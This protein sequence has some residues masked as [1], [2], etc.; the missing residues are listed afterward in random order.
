MLLYLSY[1]PTEASVC[2]LAKKRVTSDTGLDDLGHPFGLNSVYV[3]DKRRR[4]VP[5]GCIGELC[6]SGPQVALGYLKDPEQT[7]KVFFDNPFHSGSIM[8]ATGDLVRLS[9]ID[10]SI[11]YLGRRDTQVKIRG[12]RVELGEIEEVL[13]AASNAVANAAVVKVDIGHEALVAFLQCRSDVPRPDIVGVRDDNVGPLLASLRHAIYQKLPTYMAPAT[14]VVLNQFPLTSSGKLDRN[15]LHAYF[16]SHEKELRE[17]DLDNEAGIG[18]LDSSA[19]P[20]T[21]L[22][23]AI[24]SLWA[25]ILHLSPG[26]LG[27]DDNFY[28]LGGDSISAIRLASAAREAGI[29]LV[30]TDI[31]EHPTIRAM[32]HISQSAIV[33]HDFDD[34]DIP[35]VMLEQMLP[36]DLTLMD[37]DQEGL[38]ALRDDLLPKH[39]LFPRHGQLHWDIFWHSYDVFLV[40]SSTYTHA[41]LCRPASS[42]R[43]FWSMVPTLSDRPMIFPPEQTPSKSNKHSKTLSITSTERSSEPSSFLTPQRTASCKS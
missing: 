9:P 18:A 24:R 12:L 3:L 8:Y 17:I 25:A 27:I 22:H 33:N 40:T 38:D 26:S 37:L 41:Q 5:L 14:Y 39:N 31:T 1:G 32:A 20:K 7:A 4:L 29:H 16:L 30:A 6:V 28:E 34:D 42:W 2:I 10:G 35:S 11:I 36:S 19:A 13:K 23:L 43:A 15:A 21:D